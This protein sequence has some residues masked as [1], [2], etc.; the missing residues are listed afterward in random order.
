MAEAQTSTPTVT[1]TTETSHIIYLWKIPVDRSYVF[2]LNSVLKIA[3][4]FLSLIAFICVASGR[5]AVCDIVYASSYNY[6]EFVSMSLFLTLLLSWL[7]NT[8][9]LTKRM[10]MRLLP[11]IFIDLIY[12]GIYIILYIIADIVVAAQSCG[13]DNNKAGSAFGFFATGCL[14]AIGIFL[15]L[16]LRQT[17]QEAGANVGKGPDY[18]PD[19]NM[20]QY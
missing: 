17:R 13:K 7:L 2:S 18:N 3:S 4:A 12:C 10:F 6:F 16:A 9:T 1:Q 20:E 11:W 5:E 8:L 19:R 14:I 15:F